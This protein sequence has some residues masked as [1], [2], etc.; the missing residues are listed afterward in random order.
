MSS[1]QS[2][3]SQHSGSLAIARSFNGRP[4]KVIVLGREGGVVV[5]SGAGDDRKI[6]VPERDVMVFND[7]LYAGL[8]EAFKTGD[9]KRLDNLWK[10][11]KPIFA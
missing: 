1:L 7:Q 3:Q 8:S 11:A 6:G 10:S 5:L 4:G 9:R 2:A